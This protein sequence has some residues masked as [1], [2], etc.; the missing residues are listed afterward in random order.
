LIYKDILWNNAGTI[1]IKME[2]YHAKMDLFTRGA[3]DF[4]CAGLM[5]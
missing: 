1:Q 2:Q 4:V 5:R 3:K